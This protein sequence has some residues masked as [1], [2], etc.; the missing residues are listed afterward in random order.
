MKKRSMKI[1]NSSLIAGILSVV[2]GILFCIF[3]GEIVSWMMTAIGVVLIVMGILDIIA[4][5][6]T[7]GII[8]IAIGV[9]I[10]VCGWLIV[11]IVL[12]ILGIL[13][14]VYGVLCIKDIKVKNIFSILKVV[15][16]IAL[17]VLL[18]INKFAALDWMFIVIGVIAIVNGCIILLG[19]KK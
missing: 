5:N 2:I 19:L 9:A 1:S 8:E 17:G 3:K 11:Q 7:K 10:I 14:V 15:L 4:K 12:L 13:L 6:L 16:L 18:I